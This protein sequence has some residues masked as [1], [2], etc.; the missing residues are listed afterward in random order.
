[1]INGTLSSLFAVLLI[2]FLIVGC[3][4]VEENR[5]ATLSAELEKGKQIVEANCFVCHGQ[6][7]NG[8]PIIGN[9]KMWG[10]RVTQGKP[11]LIEHA[12]NGY[13]LMPAKGGNT[14]LTDSDIGLAVSY[15][16]SQLKQN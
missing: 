7:I 1:M 8:A 2:S 6:G 5:S 14:D 15:M 13:E 16:L 4:K 11:V 10:K 12:I 9:N 3:D